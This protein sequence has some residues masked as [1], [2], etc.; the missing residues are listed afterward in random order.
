MFINMCSLIVKLGGYRF[1][2]LK[3]LI[4]FALLSQHALSIL[5][6]NIKRYTLKEI[7]ILNIFQQ[8]IFTSAIKMHVFTKL[9]NSSSWESIPFF[10]KIH[11]L[12]YNRLILFFLNILHSQTFITNLY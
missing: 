2:D 1:F 12:E 6:H 5:M 7:S 10:K 8:W 9:K 11:I 4:C 3:N